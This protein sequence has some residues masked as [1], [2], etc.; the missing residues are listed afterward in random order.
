MD[1]TSFS[2]PGNKTRDLLPGVAGELD[3][4]SQDDPFL[5]LS[6]PAIPESI[7]RPFYPG[8][9]VILTALESQV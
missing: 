8:I 3:Q 7:Q 2:I 6:K 1:M 9:Y 4:V 5:D